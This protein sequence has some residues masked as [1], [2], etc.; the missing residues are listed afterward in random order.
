MVPAAVLDER[1]VVLE[2]LRRPVAACDSPSSVQFV[3]IDDSLADKIAI[4]DRDVESGDGRPDCLRRPDRLVA[5][6]TVVDLAYAGQ[7]VSLAAPLARNE[8]VER[9][10]KPT[11]VVLAPMRWVFAGEAAEPGRRLAAKGRL[12]GQHGAR[13]GVSSSRTLPADVTATL[14]PQER[15]IARRACCI[16]VYSDMQSRPAI[17][18]EGVR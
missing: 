8:T 3:A 13:A 12:W 10:G 17:D 16:V 6:P 9:G 15:S 11:I 14:G 5:S 2:G 7:S 4:T 18:S 1:S